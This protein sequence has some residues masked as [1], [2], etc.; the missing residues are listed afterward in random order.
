MVYNYRFVGESLDEFGEAAVYY[1]NISEL[2]NERFKQAIKDK[3]DIITKTP[4]ANTV[5]RGYP[6]YRKV[7]L[8]R[9]PFYLVFSINERSK[10]IYIVSIFHIKRNPEDLYKKLKK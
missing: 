3:L 4:T 7:K 5:V 10:M 2:L 1:F 6:K 8:K 9:F